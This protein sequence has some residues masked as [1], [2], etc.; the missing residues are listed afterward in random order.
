MS[1]YIS[2]LAGTLQEFFK[3]MGGFILKKISSA[4]NPDSG[5]VKLY[6]KTDGAL[7]SKDDAGTETEFSTGSA[8]PNISHIESNQSMIAWDI[9]SSSTTFD[10]ININDFEDQSGVDTTLSQNQIYDAGNDWWR[11]SV[12]VTCSWEASVVNPSACYTVV[13]VE[14]QESYT[15]GTDFKAY[16]S[17]TDGT[18]WEEF[19]DLDVYR[20]WGS[21][22]DFLR[23]DISVLSAMGDQTMRLKLTNAGK[24]IPI[25]AVSLGVKY[26]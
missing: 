17:T 4:T 1:L 22:T 7:Y 21:N 15:A 14:A 11:A 5:Y 19:E 16:V 24:D 12:L 10:D 25:A 13:R 2:D 23:G 6:F 18:F 26:S 8:T 9:Y 3:T 20:E